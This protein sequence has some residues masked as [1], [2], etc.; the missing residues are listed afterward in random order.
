MLRWGLPHG[1]WIVRAV[2]KWRVRQCSGTNG[3]CVLRFVQRGVRLCCRV[4]LTNSSLFQCFLQPSH[5]MLLWTAVVYALQL[6]LQLLTPYSAM[7]PS[8]TPRLS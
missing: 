2:P 5:W 8:T 1:Q 4:D 7:D 6:L 3:R